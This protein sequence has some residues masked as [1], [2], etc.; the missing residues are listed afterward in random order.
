MEKPP[1]S[2]SI[3]ADVTSF[4]QQQQQ[5]IFLNKLKVEFGGEVLPHLE[6]RH[7][8]NAVGWERARR[9]GHGTVFNRGSKTFPGSRH[10]APHQ[11]IRGCVYW[12]VSQS[13][14]EP[15]WVSLEM[16]LSEWVCVLRYESSWVSQSVWKW[17]WVNE[18][19]CLEMKLR[20][21]VSES[22]ILEKLSKHSPFFLFFFFLFNSVPCGVWCPC[23]PP[24]Y[25][26]PSPS[27]AVP[28]QLCP[29]VLPQFL[30]EDISDGW[31][32]LG[33]RSQLANETFLTRHRWQ[34]KEREGFYSVTRNYFGML[35]SF[36]RYYYEWITCTSNDTHLLDSVIIPFVSQ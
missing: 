35:H 5:Q 36:L 9:E 20:E 13:A 21:S 23:V 28:S 10:V 33:F 24:R 17:I 34:L 11:R 15:P 8:E 1:N 30:N 7:V 26:S 25:L 22:V 14:S 6:Y 4:H 16:N 2:L 18:S 31:V 27:H 3:R 32:S 29:L 12:T 19:V